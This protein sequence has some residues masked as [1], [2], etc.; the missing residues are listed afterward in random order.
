MTAG[1]PAGACPV[2]LAVNPASPTVTADFSPAA[3]GENVVSMLT[4]T[5][6]NANGFALTQSSLT[7]TLPAGLDM[8]K[9]ATA[10]ALA[11]ATTCTGSAATLSASAASVTLSNAIIPAR[12]SCTITVPVQSAA[13]GSYLNTIAVNALS[14]GPA[15][16]NAV[17]AGATLTVRPPSTNGGGQLD[18]WD[19]LFIAG[20]LLA[21]RRHGR[22]K[23]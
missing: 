22:R 4:L 7:E 5:L 23:P 6:A 9:A 12:S 1:T 20:V 8:A 14:T 17:A 10:A 21:G 16:Q 18:W 3:V 2:P 19:S 13:N 15:G 11:P